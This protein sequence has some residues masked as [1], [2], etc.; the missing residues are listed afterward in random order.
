MLYYNTIYQ[1]C[2][3][4][5]LSG[6]KYLELTYVRT[7]VMTYVVRYMTEAKINIPPKSMGVND[8]EYGTILCNFNDTLQ[9][10]R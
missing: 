8:I 2:T 6:K 5:V 3:A 4:I 1:Q 7:N 9:L 10:F